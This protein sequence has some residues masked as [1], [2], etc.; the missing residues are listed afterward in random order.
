MLRRCIFRHFFC[1]TLELK[2]RIFLSMHNQ[3][4]AM[5]VRSFFPVMK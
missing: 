1:K 3:F 5:D 2:T 4:V